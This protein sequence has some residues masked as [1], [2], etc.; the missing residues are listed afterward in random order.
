[1]LQGFPER[2]WPPDRTPPAQETIEYRDLILSWTAD[3]RRGLDY[4]ATRRD[5]DLDRIA[6]YGTSV[7]DGRKLLLPAVEPRYRSVIM[8]GSGLRQSFTRVLPEINPVNF[9]P[10]I[11][12]P[13]LLLQGRYDE[14]LPLKYQAEPLQRLLRGQKRII[15]YDG[16]HIPP[17]EISVPPI[18][19][20]LDETLGPVR[21]E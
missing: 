13:K 4:V 17:P 16:G 1:V 11:R 18:N 5:L 19:A 8:I 6:Y 15:L 2:E 3:E 20:W 10:Q 14:N 21:R 12:A 9:L 7:G